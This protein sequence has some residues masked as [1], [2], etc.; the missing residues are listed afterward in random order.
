MSYYGNILNL[1]YNIVLECKQSSL[2][3][4]VYNT[5]NVVNEISL[6]Q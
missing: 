1:Y 3:H 6:T 5:P 2:Y 4:I